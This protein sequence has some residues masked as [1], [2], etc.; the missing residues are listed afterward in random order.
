MGLNLHISP[1]L[2]E[3]NK[4]SKPQNNALTRKVTNVQYQIGGIYKF[5][6]ELKSKFIL[7]C[8]V[9]PI[10]TSI[11]LLLSL[12]VYKLLLDFGILSGTNTLLNVFLS[13]SVVMCIPGY[14]CSLHVLIEFLW[15]KYVQRPK[16]K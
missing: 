1:D 9:L 11:L 15:N 4:K 8:F 10:Y 16:K 7:C 12:N 13:F 14:V 2:I 6:S 3:Q 5:L